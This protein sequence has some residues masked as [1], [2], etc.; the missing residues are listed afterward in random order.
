MRTSV[1]W[2]WVPLCLALAQSVAG[3]TAADIATRS[4]LEALE[5]KSMPDVSLAILERVVADP[6]ASPELKKE[7]PF[8][9]AAALVAMSRTQADSKKRAAFLDEAQTAIDTFLASGGVSD[10]QA[11]SAYTQ[12]A[13]LLIERGRAK[14]DQANR[15]GADEKALRAEAVKFF[16]EAIKSLAGTAKPGQPIKEVKN[17]E[18]A[19][20]RVLREVTEQVD[21]I[22]KAGEV[23]D[24]DKP[25]EKPAPG[26]KL[27]QPKP[28]RLTPQQQRD[29]EALTADQEALQAKLIQTRLIT[30]AAMFEKAKA[31]PE[32]SKEWAETIAKSAELFKEVADRYPNKGGGLFARYFEGRNYALL[33]KY[34]LAVQTL[35]FLASLEQK[36]PL[37]VTL[38]SRALSTMLECLVAEKLYDDFDDSA[39]KFALED[40]SR[41]P[42]QQLDAEWLALKY[43]AAVILDARADALDAK[44]PKS[45]NDRSKLIADAKKLAIEVAKANLDFSAEAR[46]LA[47]KY[48]KE[49]A[50][51]EQ[52]FAMVMDEAKLAL[53]IM[54]ARLAEVK[55]AK[56]AK[57]E[58][59]AAAA[60]EAAGTARNDTITKLEAAMKL[61]GI[62]SPLAADA[63]GDGAI[64]DAT[65]DE[66]HQC[67][68]LL[69]YL[70]YDG[71]RYEESAT[72]GRLFV[73]QYPNAKGSRQAAKI[74]MSAWQQLAQRSEGD[75]RDKARGSAAKLAA[76]VMRIW[77][78]D[79]DAASVVISS[80][81]AAR[82][83]TAIMATMDQVPASSPKRGEV[84]LRAGAA[85]WREV[86][87]ARRDTESPTRPD[88]KVIEAWKSRAR[89][90]LDDGLASAASATSL[91]PGSTGA[92]T[93][94]GALSRVQIAMDDDDTATALTIL[95]Q[96]VFGPWTLVSSGSPVMQQGS[97]TEA[98]L[99]LALRLFIQ[100]EKFEQAQQAMDGLEKAA[101]TGEEASTK[102]TS[103]YLSMGRDLQSQLEQ[104]G[105][106]KVND[107]QV[108]A[109]AEKILSGFEKFLDRV[110][111]RDSKISSQFW[112]ATTYLTL[113]SGKGT[114]AVVPKDKADRYLT[115]SVEVYQ[116]LLGKTADPEVARFE[117][118]IRLRM[119]N[120][121][122]EL[123]QWDEAQ[124]QL[125][126]FLAD[127]KRQNS[128][129]T[130]IQAAELLQAAADD[131][132]RN[133]ESDKANTLYRQAA[134]GRRGE[135]DPVVIWGWGNIA[136]K[137]ARQ[138]ISGD[139]EKSRQAR[140]AFF[141]ARFRVV[142]C[143]L[144]RAKL[145]GKEA[146]RKSRLDT[147][148]A[149]IT[150]THNLYPDLGGPAMTGKFDALLKMVQGEKG[151]ANPEGLA[152]TKA[153]APEK[154]GKQ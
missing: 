93:V 120:I 60:Q 115:R 84:F 143:L 147:A 89:T 36:I 9:R 16:D 122:Q 41:L 112:V 38:R 85:L 26:T 34:E 146:D 142:E 5:D 21:A 94:A 65:I 8:R 42:G 29:L 116:S 43:R 19:V 73:D 78:D 102:L 153:A 4:L 106:G 30:A 139:D 72:L 138:S 92:I 108:R 113:G 47:A 123:K 100:A 25:K 110:A 133:G 69:T 98:S 83:P 45:K 20:T 87:D 44:D 119:A 103:M 132:A 71:Q 6:K 80:A 56:A 27:A 134:G 10:R 35:T 50:E 31:Y 88:D 136:N 86:Q 154:E 58:A 77:P 96:P 74:A 130:Q 144:A 39:R 59:K 109:K 121:Y 131:A 63:S 90:A 18:D 91:P 76:D 57:D 67:R 148:E 81:I 150:I 107:P 79:P 11:I 68:Y 28:L 7:V 127:A 151:V 46:E 49:V 62:V 124:K 37:A 13:N 14:T 97:L 105:A 141:N 3:E 61:A 117:P 1:C 22:K 17:A 126:W 55:E 33:G 95:E 114:G 101:G 54:Q 125:D 51:G 40:V 15:P 135:G 129:D 82:D 12:K 23:D 2:I 66:I 111:A 140:D 152:A 145:P 149:A 118:S 53:G 70:L 48:G 64:Q 99:T 75:A 104:L 137:L 24:K 32:K 52:T 128:L